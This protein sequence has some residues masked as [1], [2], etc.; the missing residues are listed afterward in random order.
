MF[1]QNCGS[2]IVASVIEQSQSRKSLANFRSS[3]VFE[4]AKPRLEFV[5]HNPLRK[6]SWCLSVLSWCFST[7]LTGR[8]VSDGQFRGEFEE[9]KWSRVGRSSRKLSLENIV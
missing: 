9:F 1:L 6:R 3:P 5:E 2:K 4:L 8:A 7:I